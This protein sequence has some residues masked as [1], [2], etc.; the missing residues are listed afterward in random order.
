MA[1]LAFHPEFAKAHK[2]R[3]HFLKEHLGSASLQPDSLRPQPTGGVNYTQKIWRFL[4]LF[5]CFETT[6]PFAQENRSYLRARWYSPS[7]PPF[8]PPSQGLEQGPLH[9]GK[10]AEMSFGRQKIF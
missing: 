6:L 2:N 4:C 10:K 3:E 5:L 9:L 7:P 8:S 1:T